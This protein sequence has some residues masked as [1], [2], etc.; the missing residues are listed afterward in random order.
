[1]CDINKVLLHRRDGQVRPN[2]DNVSDTLEDRARLL[3]IGNIGIHIGYDI[4]ID[5]RYLLSEL[6]A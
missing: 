1:M 5:F 6:E 3:E 2:R 4:R